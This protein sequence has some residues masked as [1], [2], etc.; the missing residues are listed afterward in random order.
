MCRRSFCLVSNTRSRDIAAQENRAVVI[1]RKHVLVTVTIPISEVDPGRVSVKEVLGIRAHQVDESVEDRIGVRARVRIQPDITVPAAENHVF[2]AV[3]VNVNKDRDCPI[4]G[5]G[6]TIE[7]NWG[8]VGEDR[9]RVRPD[10]EIDIDVARGA[11]A[12]LS[13]K[14]VFLAIG[15]VI[16]D[17]GPGVVGGLDVDAVRLNL[18][19]IG[20]GAV[21]QPAEIGEVAVSLTGDQVKIPVLVP[22]ADCD[23]CT[24][25]S[26]I[27]YGYV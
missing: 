7:E 1:A 25:A 26:A 16:A 22:V 6:A 20:Q 8:R 9:C 11:D 17:K 24:L 27:G 12:F 15:I 3:H 19:R 18:S 14:E 10:V 2:F 5:E 23:R 21:G 4:V 13:D